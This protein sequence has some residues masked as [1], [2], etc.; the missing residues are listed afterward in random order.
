MI[1]LETRQKNKLTLVIEQEAPFWHPVRYQKEV[2]RGTILAAIW[3]HSFTR[4]IMVL[5]KIGKDLRR[6][7]IINGKDQFTLILLQRQKW[8]RHMILID[9]GIRHKYVLPLMTSM[10][11]H[12]IPG[13]VLKRIWQAYQLAKDFLHDTQTRHNFTLCN[14]HKDPRL[15]MGW[16]SSKSIIRIWEGICKRSRSTL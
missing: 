13:K 9:S 7:N 4:F 8:Q 6:I 3:K 5:I 1:Y 15:E 10:Q 2:L 16:E 12:L 11:H 14:H